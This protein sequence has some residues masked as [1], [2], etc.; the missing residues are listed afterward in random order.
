MFV[1]LKDIFS[2]E[3][4]CQLEVRLFGRILRFSSPISEAPRPA[5]LPLS[6]FGPGCSSPGQVHALRRWPSRYENAYSLY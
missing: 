2:G 5:K 1:R 4:E 6:N 3:T